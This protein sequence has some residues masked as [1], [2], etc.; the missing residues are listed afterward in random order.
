MKPV[1][2]TNIHLLGSVWCV[3][4][5]EEEKEAQEGEQPEEDKEAGRGET[6]AVCSLSISLW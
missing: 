4:Q 6:R 2:K 3:Q 5:A 1:Q